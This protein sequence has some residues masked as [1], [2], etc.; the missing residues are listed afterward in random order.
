MSW[1]GQP[2]V[3]PANP[4]EF[5]ALTLKM[6]VRRIGPVNDR[7]TALCWHF[8]LA[9]LRLP[10]DHWGV[11]DPYDYLS[12]VIQ[13]ESRNVAAHWRA[14]VAV[15]VVPAALAAWETTAQ[16]IAKLDAQ[17]PWVCRAEQR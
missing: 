9:S 12:E 5:K 10:R 2:G 17:F 13:P 16:A 4:S 1:T 15:P 3:Q 8:P 7:K 14:A 11:P 6:S